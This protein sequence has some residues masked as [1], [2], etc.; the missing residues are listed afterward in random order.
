MSEV[1]PHPSSQTGLHLI[2]KEPNK[3]QFEPVLDT[4]EAASLLGIH[5]KTLQKLARAK[6]VPAVRIGSAGPFVPP[7]WTRG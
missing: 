5:P 1:T 6:K 4:D 3:P 2:G 7:P